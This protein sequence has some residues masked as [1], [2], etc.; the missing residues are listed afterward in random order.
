MNIGIAHVRPGYNQGAAVLGNG[1][2]A[3]AAL[4]ARTIK[5]W[6]SPD[7]AL[8]YPGQSWGG[9]P[10]SLTTLAQL[11][12]YAAVLGSANFDRYYLGTWSFAN[13]VNDPWKGAL[14]STQI[15]A[16]YNEVYALAAHLLATY[17]GKDF[18]IQ[19]AESDWAILNGVGQTP[20]DPN[21]Q[22]DPRLADRAVAF[23]SARVRAI[24]DARHA[25]PSSSRVL[26]CV[27]CNRVLDD[28]GTRVH[29]DILPRVEPDVVSWTSY[30]AIDAD[31]VLGT[32]TQGQ[33]E[34]R[35]ALKTAEAFRRIREAMTKA[36]GQRGAHVPIVVGEVGWPEA[37]PLFAQPGGYDAGGFLTA[38]VTAANALGAVGINAWQLWD[39]DVY[40]D[41]APTHPQRR[42]VYDENGDLTAQGTV[43]AALLAS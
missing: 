8:D 17:S 34:E 14:T 43:L 35:I 15:Q 38:L 11:A 39:N 1:A 3:I 20:Y 16:E 19:T 9:A 23:F 32:L 7:Y 31:W 6:A 42:A 21:N 12:P 13:G 10:T 4:G 2:A 18:V 22:I 5:L 26:S 24:R 40:T 36:Q 33:V 25:V 29:R 28:V 30:E 37:H 27:E 41:P